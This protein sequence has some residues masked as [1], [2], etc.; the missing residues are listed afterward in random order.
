MNPHVERLAG[1]LKAITDWH[2]AFFRN[3]SLPYNRFRRIYEFD[4]EGKKNNYYVQE[5]V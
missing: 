3:R 5:S 2:K 1:R 4:T